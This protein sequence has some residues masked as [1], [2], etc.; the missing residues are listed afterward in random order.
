M[1][2]IKIGKIAKNGPKCQK[3]PHFFPGTSSSVKNK[4]NEHCKKKKI[5]LAGFR[6]TFANTKFKKIK[7]NLKIPHIHGITFKRWLD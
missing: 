7:K 2:K 3:G 5:L 6:E 4:K 1:K